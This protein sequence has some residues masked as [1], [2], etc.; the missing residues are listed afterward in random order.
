MRLKHLFRPMG[1]QTL[2]NEANRE[3]WIIP[4][5]SDLRG[6]ELDYDTVWVL[7][8]VPEE[9]YTE[10]DKKYNVKLAYLFDVKN[11]KMI[12][13]NQNFIERCIILKE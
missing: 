1:F 5:A 11:Q 9:I 3:G 13:V 2:I 12:I 4:L 6:L 7:N 10:E 8:P